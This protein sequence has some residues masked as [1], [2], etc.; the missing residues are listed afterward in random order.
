MFTQPSVGLNERV[1]YAS[2]EW[3]A[4]AQRFLESRCA[5]HPGA[6]F[7]FS[8]PLDN[9]PPHLNG[10]D[11]PFGY[12]VR[13]ADGTVQTETRPRTDVDLF[14]RGD[15]NAGLPM[16]WG[17]YG[18]DPTY[19]ERIVRE[20]RHLARDRAGEPVGAMPE[21]PALAGLLGEMHDHLARR[22]LNN[23]DV[24]HRV[25]HYGLERHVAELADTG[26]TVLEDAFTDEYALA[27]REETHR[28]HSGRAEDA[29]FRATMLLERGQIWEEAVIHPW[30]V[31]L[32][33]HLLGRGNLIYQSD[34][35][36]KGPGRDTPPGLHS[37]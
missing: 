13:I 32:A 6:S 18:D 27:L 30:V 23:P 28:N 14:Q 22:T 2:A 5:A 21:D 31:T 29:S 17:V 4:E 34:T 11:E 7:S 35:I 37:D 8:A 19:R 33:D 25:K 12:T 1:E 16:A 20:Y 24:A 3:R 15:Y 9:P 36:V 10:G 26:Y